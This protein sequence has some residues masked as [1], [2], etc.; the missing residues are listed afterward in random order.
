MTSAGKTR[1]AENT[2]AKV[3]KGSEEEE[4]SS[5][6]SYLLGDTHIQELQESAAQLEGQLRQLQLDAIDGI[7]EGEVCAAVEA[8]WNDLIKLVEAINSNAEAITNQGLDVIDR[9][10]ELMVFFRRGF[11]AFAHLQHI[12]RAVSHLPTAYRTSL[13]AALRENIA[14]LKREMALLKLKAFDQLCKAEDIEME[15]LKGRIEELTKRLLSI[16]EA[17]SDASVNAAASVCNDV[18]ELWPPGLKNTEAAALVRVDP[19]QTEARVC[20]SPLASPAHRVS[21]FWR[22]PP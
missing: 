19:A 13:N 17:E 8:A 4:D 16:R 1:R 12:R 21:F 5:D 18:E 11:W 9:G 20:L 15:D 14:Q 10:E 3:V 2:R 7:Q 22:D 6:L